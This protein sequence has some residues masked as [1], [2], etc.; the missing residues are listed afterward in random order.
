[1]TTFAVPTLTPAQPAAPRRWWVWA[2]VPAVL[3]ALGG[4]YWGYTAWAAGRGGVAN[5]KFHTV[6]K[7][8]EMIVKV[9]KDGELQA[10]NNVDVMSQVE[11]LATIV[12]I[13][14]EG[15]FV[16][17]GT[18]L[19]R[20]DS[21]TIHQ[22]VE[23]TT[24]ELKR[25]DSDVAT[26]RNVLQ[27]QESTNAANLEAAE[28][29]V[30]LAEL[31]MKQYKE[32]S[33]PPELEQARTELK[34][35]E[36]TLANKEDDLK[37]TK[38][39]FS[40]GFVN[41]AD[42]KA[43]EL[44]L[45][46]VRNSAAKAKSALVLLEQYTYPMMLAGKE[47][48]LKQSKQKRERTKIENQ[49][50]LTKAQTAL[51]NQEAARE[52]LSRRLERLKEQ[53]AFCTI[54]STGSGLVVYNNASSRGESTT[55]QEGTQVRERQTILRIPDTSRMKAVV[56]INESQVIRVAEGQEALVK[57]TGLTTPI[58]ATVKRISPV[59]DS[60]NRWM[61]PD[62]REYPVELELAQT[63]PN[64]KPGI[65][66]Q[67]EVFVTTIPDAVAVPLAA[68]YSAGP[69][70]YVFVRNGDGT[71]TAREVTVGTANETQAQIVRGVQP[72]DDV[73]LLE[74]GQGRDLLEKNNIKP[75][76]DDAPR[77]KGGKKPAGDPK[78]A[79]EKPQPDA[80][81]RD[82]QGRD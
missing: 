76:A 2:L 4:T 78:K 9:H 62:T 51:L 23:D 53:E 73:V 64:L 57:I 49:N 27:I 6:A 68:I 30:W 43:A 7:P 54:K 29:D 77:G 69:K 22:K 19:V 70:T 14:K 39:L 46:T 32:G 82:A 52:I 55:I 24:L 8:A 61:N 79:G 42:V 45:E 41:L 72:G 26:A 1:M 11:G 65:S 48:Y 59:A 20:L 21:S 31:S 75:P 58:P 10:E 71:P 80:H 38:E 63:P 34:M 5:Y 37:Q 47:S 33:Y 36:I 81:G 15:E 56:R 16:H 60:S 74:A 12:E 17:P 28:V 50:N 66:V 67:V 18:L 25:A 44:A 13:V 3:L 40:K 35:Q